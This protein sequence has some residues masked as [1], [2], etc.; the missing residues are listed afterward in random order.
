LIETKSEKKAAAQVAQND[1]L[2]YPRTLVESL[3][4]Q[5]QESNE[6]QKAMSAKFDKLQEANTKQGRTIDALYALSEENVRPPTDKEPSRADWQHTAER[7]TGDN[8]LS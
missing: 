8:D 6:V 4:R 7:D 5:I 3:F 1:Q 2:T